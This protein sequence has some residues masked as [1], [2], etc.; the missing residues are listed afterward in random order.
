[1]FDEARSGQA[2][3]GQRVGAAGSSTIVPD[4]LRGVACQ[5]GR[6]GDG[7]V[8]DIPLDN[9]Q[10]ISRGGAFDALGMLGRWGHE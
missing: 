10:V 6:V 2:D 8:G 1:M 3:L 5:R 4:N 9:T 7:G